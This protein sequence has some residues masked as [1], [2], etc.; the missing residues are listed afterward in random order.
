MIDFNISFDLPL[1]ELI[2]DIT[3][4]IENRIKS[5]IPDAKKEL[6][7]QLV[8]D[9]E[10]YV[11]YKTGLLNNSVQVY[12]QDGLIVYH[13]PYASF[14]FDPETAY[15]FPKNYNTSVHEEAR[16]YPVEYAYENN[17]DNYINMLIEKLLEDF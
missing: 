5:K 10:P 3:E 4:D 17:E 1:S 13:A 2:E 12:P 11:P 16:G 7:Y 6:L 14:A 15:G 8:K 9:A